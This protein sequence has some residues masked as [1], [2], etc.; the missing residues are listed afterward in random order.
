[1]REL[2][3]IGQV[4]LDSTD[5]SASHVRVEFNG[6]IRPAAELTAPL[7]GNWRIESNGRWLTTGGPSGQADIPFMRN[8]ISTNF[9]QHGCTEQGEASFPQ[10]RAFVSTWGYGNVYLNNS[11]L[12]EDIWLH[13]MYTT[14]MRE[15]GTNT[16]WAD[17]AHTR[18]QC[19]LP[20]CTS[21]APSAATARSARAAT[22]LLSQLVDFDRCVPIFAH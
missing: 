21:F 10:I 6:T 20:P 7:T 5:P 15:A 13:T 8:G 18:Y 9:I 22:L 4:D 1:V 3:A 12:Y 11:I 16:I 19:T 14:R 2:G 17:A